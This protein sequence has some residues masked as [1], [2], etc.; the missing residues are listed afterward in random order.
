[1]ITG[2]S[3]GIGRALAIE[4]SGPK[5]GCEVLATARSVDSIADLKEKGLSVAAVDVMK[6]ET[7]QDAVKGFGRVDIVIANA[8]LSAFGP[9][10]EQDLQKIEKVLATNVT[11]VVATIQ[12]VASKMVEER[13]GTVVVIGSISGSLVLPYSGAYCSSKAA[14]TALCDALVRQSRAIRV[15]ACFEAEIGKERHRERDTDFIRRAYS[16]T[17]SLATRCSGW[18]SNPSAF[19]LSRLSRA[20]FDQASA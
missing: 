5:R 16:S 7:L 20:R 8:G 14:I 11:G 6:P 2:C 9:L 1:M 15:H 19:R 3:S 18:S 10:V 17:L 13:R 4:L 12:S